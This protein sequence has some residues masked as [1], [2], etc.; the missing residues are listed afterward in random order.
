MSDQVEGAI[1][2]RAHILQ[3]GLNC[4]FCGSEEVVAGAAGLFF[5]GAATQYRLCKACAR[6]WVDTYEL[7]GFQP[8]REEG[9]EDA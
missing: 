8:L 7:T 6:E 4:P 2:A 3:K 5:K 1:T 9:K